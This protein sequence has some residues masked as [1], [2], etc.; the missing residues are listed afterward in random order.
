MGKKKLSELNF[1]EKRI[2]KSHKK[3]FQVKEGEIISIGDITL[4]QLNKEWED[5]NDSSS[6][7]LLLYQ[8]I[9]ILLTGDAS[10]QT[11]KYILD[12]YDLEEIDILKA[13]HHGSKTSTST[14]LLEE[15]KPKFVFIYCGKNNKFNHPSIETILKLEAFEIPYYRTDEVGTITFD[16]NRMDITLEG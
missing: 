9:R 15:L 1:F 10:I 2:Q 7:F 11:E 8:D 4:I 16:F 3:V 6:V 12:T 5:E 13:G 14:E